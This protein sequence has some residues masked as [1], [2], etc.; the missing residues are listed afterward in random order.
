LTVA[1]SGVGGDELFA[2]Y[3]SFQ[4]APRL[5]RLPFGQRW[6]DALPGWRAG[7]PVLPGSADMRRK[8]AA[9]LA[10]D[11]VLRHPYFAVRGL[12]T[13]SQISSLLSLSVVDG[14]QAADQELLAWQRQVD[15]QTELA[16]RYDAIGEVSWLELSQYMR[17]TL[18][19]D[20]DM[21]SMAHSL[22]VRV[23]FVDHVL[24]EAMLG[25][26]G[27]RKLHGQP[28]KPLLNAA[29]T[30]LLPV[31]VTAS[32]KRTFTFPFETWLRAGLAATVQR[33]LA[34]GAADPSAVLRGEAVMGVWRDFESGRTNWAR[35]WALYV[36]HEWLQRHLA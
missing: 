23:P 17:S 1:L 2:G 20:T 14:A 30:G 11:T 26:P 5:K 21:M 35:P 12:F 24:V 29:L 3:R 18:L 7:W 33:R 22:E 15:A 34:A 13:R 19:R 6:L 28:P 9:Y 8:S 27:Q 32:A 25:V 31:Q 36:L 16:G 4:L 10:G